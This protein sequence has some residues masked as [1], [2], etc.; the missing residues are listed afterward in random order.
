MRVEAKTAEDTES[1]GGRLARSY[2]QRDE[3]LAVVYLTGALGPG[4]TT[5]ARGF[6]RAQRIQGPPRSPSYTLLQIY[7]T[8]ARATVHSDLYR[9]RDASDLANLG[10]RDWAQ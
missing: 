6:L 1:L 4:K 9:L 2:P 8:G 5:F 3:G 7:E 10:L